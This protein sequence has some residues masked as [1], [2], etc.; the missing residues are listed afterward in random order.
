MDKYLFTFWPDK[1]S[2]EHFDMVVTGSLEEAEKLLDFLVS[3]PTFWAAFH[4][5][6]E[7]EKSHE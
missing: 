5:M 7:A 2:E 1:E 4:L 3:I 6:N